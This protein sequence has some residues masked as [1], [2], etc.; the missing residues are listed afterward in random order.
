MRNDDLQL[1]ALHEPVCPHPGI[2]QHGFV[3]YASLLDGPGSYRQNLLQNRKKLYSDGCRYVRHND[4]NSSA[5]YG[6]R[7]YLTFCEV[8]LFYISL[9]ACRVS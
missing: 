9:V 8:L 7:G 3:S 5:D 1:R 6:V 2:L 4:F